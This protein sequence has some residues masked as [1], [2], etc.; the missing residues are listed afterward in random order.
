MIVRA[1][2][3]IDR[4]TA[5]NL[6]CAG[7]LS[8]LGLFRLTG[9]DTITVILC[10]FVVAL[11]LAPKHYAIMVVVSVFIGLICGYWRGAV[12][13]DRLQSYQHLYGNKVIMHVFADS[14]ATYSNNAQLEFDATHIAVVSPTPTNLPGKIVVSGYGVTSILRGDTVTVEGVL[15]SRKGA[16]IAGV[17]YA[18]LRVERRS[19]SPIE[20]MRRNF[21]AGLATSLPEPHDQFAAG[22]LIGQRS[23][24]PDSVTQTLRTVG[25]SHVIAVSGYNL[26][27]MAEVARRYMGKKSKFRSTMGSIVL[28]LLFVALA[29]S[30]ASIARAAL[31]SILTICAAHYGRQVK[32]LTLLLLAAGYT[33]VQNPINLWL[34]IGW[35][36]SFLA[37]FGVLI[38]APTIIGR[39]YN[40]RQRQPH[41]ITAL[42]V[43]TVSAQIMTVPITMYVFGQVS[44]VSLVANLFVV[45][46]VPM[47]MLLS[48]VAG[49]AGMVVPQ[50]AAIVAWPAKILLD[51]ML[52]IAS[53]FS[54]LPH[55]LAHTSLV[56]WQML[57]LYAII[58]AL[59]LTLR[60]KTPDSSIIS[61]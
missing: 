24:L 7:V 5:I 38:V 59:V 36:L 3:H 25:L 37:F 40:S 45:P 4:T 18:Q 52:S 33:A 47:A 30:S 34:D 23:E 9:Y 2:R 48:V 53:L 50:V 55:A 61:E 49:L 42:L 56:A 57:A 26:T 12:F 14:S 41:P 16:K 10:L 35:Y 13:N 51:F 29:G 8:G 32:P 58:V 43:E 11:F 15:R 1:K 21:L 54:R 60:R 39:L 19:A 20:A 27:I 46:F 28:V 17:S 44:V 22:L 6:V 31:V